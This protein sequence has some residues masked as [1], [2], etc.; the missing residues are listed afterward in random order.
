MGLIFAC[1]FRICVEDAFFSFAEVKR[2]LVPALI[3]SIIVP[4]LGTFYSKD[5]MMT[6]RRVSAVEFYQMGVL[7]KVVENDGVALDTAVS[8][9]VKEI[10]EGGPQAI[11]K[12]KETVNFIG[13]HD[14]DTSFEY[15]KTVFANMMKSKEALYGMQMFM[16]KK[17]PNWNSLSKL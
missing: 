8:G 15:V 1:D 16:Q 7:T 2:G 9:I 5:L 13:A 17:K 10:L 11:Q 6:G 4:Q 14:Q 3:S 12:I